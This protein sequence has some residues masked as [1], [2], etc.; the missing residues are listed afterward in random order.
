[1]Y[2]ALDRPAHRGC[3]RR[4]NTS[5]ITRACDE[6]P[7]TWFPTAWGAKLG[8]QESFWGL[9]V[10]ELPDLLYSH[11]LLSLLDSKI[12][13]VQRHCWQDRRS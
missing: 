7:D 8:G 5:Q 3:L 12:S 9:A 1:M 11:C 10:R 13:S 2:Q 6:A 4:G